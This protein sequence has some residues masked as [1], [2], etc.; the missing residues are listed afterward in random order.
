LNVTG[1]TRA[2]PI[3]KIFAKAFRGVQTTFRMVPNEIKKMLL[4]ERC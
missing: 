4:L 2:R 3:M 1:I